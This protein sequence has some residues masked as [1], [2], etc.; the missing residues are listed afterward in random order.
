MLQNSTQVAGSTLALEHALV[1]LLLLVGL[2]SIRRETRR[3]APWVVLAG[4]GLSLLTPAHTFDLPWPIL[5]ALVL[6]PLLWQLAAGMAISRPA[7]AGKAWLAWLLTALLIGLALLLAGRIPP[8]SALLLGV[9]AA[10]LMWRVHERR[11]GGTD[12][13]AFGQL[14][15]ALLLAEV[16]VA[17]HPLGPFLGSLFAG[18]M[19]GLLLGYAGVRLALRLPGERARDLFCL[20]LAYVA[21]LLGA[22]MGGSGVVTATMTG[23]TVAVYGYSV[24]LW[25]DPELL[26]APLNQYGVFVMLAAAYLAL[27]WQADVPLT[28]FHALGIA[29][30]LAA[31]AIG[32]WLTGRLDLSWE[33]SGLPWPQL[34]WLKQRKVGLLL[35]GTLLL[36]PQ[37]A[38]LEPWPLAIALAA[39]LVAMAT[40]RILLDQVFNV[41]VVEAPPPETAEGAPEQE[42]EK[43]AAEGEVR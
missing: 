2:L 23:L 28:L 17:L 11:T 32:V 33:A 8:A 29:L 12:L 34:L 24:G 14:A 21:Y 37:A 15:L 7:L 9:L 30:G 20:G 36:W 16:D 10:S 35:L 4:V 26:P 25:R 22:L 39:A 40:L 27:G 6:P 38:V 5:S 19:L 31:A 18:A 13:G 1:M 42:G 43:E 41:M 3:Y